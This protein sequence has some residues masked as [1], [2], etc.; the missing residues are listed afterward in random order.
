LSDQGSQR[1]T[2]GSREQECLFETRNWD[3]ELLGQE[4]NFMRKSKSKNR[5]QKKGNNQRGKKNHARTKR[6]TPWS[7]NRM[8]T[9]E[10]SGFYENDT[11]RRGG[12]H[13]K[14]TGFVK[15]EP[16]SILKTWLRAR[17]T[18]GGERERRS[19]TTS[20]GEPISTGIH[21]NVGGE[22]GTH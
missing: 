2:P 14:G 20:Q 17:Q 8:G 1:Q 6:N 10:H 9:Q 13:P 5:R 12:A 22:W 21:E 19:G 15:K 11:G 16:S 18:G 3:P 4:R 7:K